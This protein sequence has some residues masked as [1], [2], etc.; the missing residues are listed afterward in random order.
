MFWSL[1]KVTDWEKVSPRRRLL[2]APGRVLILVGLVA[3]I[4]YLLHANHYSLEAKV[5]HWRHGYS[6]T[7]GSYEI[8]VPGHWL[9]L[10]ENPTNLTLAN[11]S[12]VRPQR[13]GKFHTTTVIDVDVYLTE[14]GEHSA[15]AADWK[16]SWV[17]H[18]QQR[19]ASQKVESVEEK[20]LGFAGEP[21][22]CL[23]GKE[24]SAL[25]RDKPSLPQ[26]DVISLNCMSESGLNL[27]F[28]GEPSDVQPFYTFVSQ[29]RR[30]G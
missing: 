7:I 26:M 4:G 5:W 6:T 15:R 11:I 3:A 9:V 24:L 12:P 14:F 1:V 27:R 2:C 23:G 19:L 17:S 10:A 25:L 16:E 28:V 13:D 30:R 29:I 20:T 22:T 18:E 21:I 8:P